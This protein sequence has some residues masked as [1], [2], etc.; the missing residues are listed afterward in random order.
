[1]SW[2][3]N[4]RRNNIT[5]SA[6]SAMGLLMFYFLVPL[7]LEARGLALLARLWP[8]LVSASGV[9]TASGFYQS[10]RAARCNRCRGASGTLLLWS[11][12]NAGQALLQFSQANARIVADGFQGAT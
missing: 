7:H 10:G 12:R 11:P 3:A 4:I 6:L 5:F 9:L 1:M 2:R 8:Y